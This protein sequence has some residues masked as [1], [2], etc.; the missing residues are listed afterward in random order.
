MGHSGGGMHTSIDVFVFGC[1]GQY[2]VNGDLGQSCGGMLEI[3]V[4][5]MNNSLSEFECICCHLDIFLWQY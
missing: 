4:G 3:D 2:H 1:G 5:M